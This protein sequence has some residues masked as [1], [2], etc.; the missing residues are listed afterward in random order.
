MLLKGMNVATRYELKAADMFL[1]NSPSFE[2][3]TTISNGIEICGAISPVSNRPRYAPR[4]DFLWKSA[5]Q[6]SRHSSFFNNW[7]S[8]RGVDSSASAVVHW[9][10]I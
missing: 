8:R 9:W 7:I 5:S 1:A 6:I 2:A 4:V 10:F 3:K